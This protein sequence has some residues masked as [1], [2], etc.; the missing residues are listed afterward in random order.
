MDKVLEEVSKL[1]LLLV[2]QEELKG[3]LK[4]LDMKNGVLR[5]SSAL[6]EQAKKFH[7][8]LK[9]AKAAELYR[10]AAEVLERGFVRLY[11]TRIWA[12][13]YIQLGVALCQARR[14]QEAEQAF[15]KVLE[16]LPDLELSQGYYSPS[17]RRFFSKVKAG[18]SAAS[19]APSL[20]LAKL[21][22]VAVSGSLDG[23]LVF[24][25]EKMGEQTVLKAAYFDPRSRA[26]TAVETMVVGTGRPVDLVHRLQDAIVKGLG[27]GK[28]ARDEGT[29]P[30]GQ[31]E[32][33]GGEINPGGGGDE[34]WYVE[35]WWIWPVSVLA[36]GAAAAAIALPLTVYRED[37]VDVRLHF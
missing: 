17:V 24:T 20:A 14:H 2:S 26:F 23:L 15:R 34:P 32:G 12:E 3:Y 25:S 13:P 4:R 35:H 6:L 19:A 10:K 11:D 9:L 30:G 29:S 16:A 21:E 1:P 8:G 27:I 33:G 37:V 18:Y 28:L 36:A 5:E 7:V 22:Q 31:G